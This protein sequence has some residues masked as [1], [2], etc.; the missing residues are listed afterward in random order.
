MF[1][2]GSN[3]VSNLESSTGDNYFNNIGNKKSLDNKDKT[4]NNDIKV[5]IGNNTNKN[6]KK[7]R[8]NRKRK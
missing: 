6:I 8:Q 3:V 4:N 1:D 5:E 7:T 2:Y